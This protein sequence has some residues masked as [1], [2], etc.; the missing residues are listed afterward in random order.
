MQSTEM[1][2]GARPS[3][4]SF[5]YTCCQSDTLAGTAKKDAHNVSVKPLVPIRGSITTHLSRCRPN[6][7]LRAIAFTPKTRQH[8]MGFK[9]LVACNVCD[10]L[11]KTVLHTKV[12]LPHSVQCTNEPAGR[13]SACCRLAK[14]SPTSATH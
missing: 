2:P 6:C 3:M 7:I 4:R 10:R 14:A 5:L 1:T 11:R 8:S 12:F 13:L 9:E